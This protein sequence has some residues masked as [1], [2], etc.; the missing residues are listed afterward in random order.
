MQLACIPALRIRQSDNA[1]HPG[2]ERPERP[3]P[4]SHLFNPSRIHP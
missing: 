1:G 2:G 3:E 4:V